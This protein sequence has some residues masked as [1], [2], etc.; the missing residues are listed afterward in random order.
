M[1]SFPEYKHQHSVQALA[2]GLHRKCIACVCPPILWLLQTGIS[3]AFFTFLFFCSLLFST[4]VH[5]AAGFNYFSTINPMFFS[6]R[7]VLDD[8][9]IQHIQYFLHQFL[10]CRQI[11]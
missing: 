7:T 11:T 8:Y 4:A 10:A 5:P 9:L 1:V 2:N 6:Q 3:F